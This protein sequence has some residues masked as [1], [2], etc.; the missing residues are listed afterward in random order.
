MTDRVS[1]VVASPLE[2]YSGHI[3]RVEIRITDENGAKSGEK[4]KRCMMEAHLE[5]RMRLAVT[6]QA[7]TLEDAVSGATI[8]LAKTIESTLN[9]ARDTQRRKAKD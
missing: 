5:D 6:H 8:K 7:A 1:E 4:D 2:K 9:K 3:S